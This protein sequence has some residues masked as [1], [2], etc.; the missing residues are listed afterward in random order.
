MVRVS[1]LWHSG[2]GVSR[3]KVIFRDQADES[4]EFAYWMD[5]DVY[6]K[7]ELGVYAT[8]EDYKKFGTLDLAENTDI[9]SNK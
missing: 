1:A 9:Y 8:P 5:R 7:I 4:K 3:T 6:T 2:C